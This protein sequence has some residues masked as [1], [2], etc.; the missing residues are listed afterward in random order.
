[1]WVYSLQRQALLISGWAAALDV[2]TQ[3][4]WYSINSPRE[5]REGDWA[6]LTFAKTSGMLLR[7]GK[8][9]PIAD[10]RVP[11]NDPDTIAG[12]ISA[13]VPFSFLNG[14]MDEDYC[15]QAVL[16]LNNVN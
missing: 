12:R 4:H 2:D 1:M 9:W 13:S 3:L 6:E 7:T 14:R 5:K 10:R 15:K 16:A 8:N 11:S